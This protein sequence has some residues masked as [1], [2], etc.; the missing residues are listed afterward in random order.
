MSSFTAIRL[1]LRARS[2]GGAPLAS[3]TST[4]LVVA[5]RHMH[6]SSAPRS[7][8]KDDMDRESLK[9]KTHEYTTSGTDEDVAAKQDAAF[10][11]NKTDP[12]TEKNTA[13]AESNGNPLD[14][15][16]ADKGFAEAGKGKSEDKA[17]GNQKKASVAGD[18]PKGGKI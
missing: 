4:R 11:P 10:N 7:P 2:V 9:P 12:D 15:S 1:A 8:Y 16:P 3:A 17:Y 13:A 14:G 6:Q 5:S 18:A